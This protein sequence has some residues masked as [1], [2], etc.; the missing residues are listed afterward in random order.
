[1]IPA[2]R[3]HRDSDRDSTP[4]TQDSASR[5]EPGALPERFRRRLR[6]IAWQAVSEADTRDGFVMAAFDEQQ[7]RAELAARI[8]LIDQSLHAI[9]DEVRCLPV[10]AYPGGRELAVARDRAVAALTKWRDRYLPRLTGYQPPRV[11]GEQVEIRRPSHRP[12]KPWEIATLGIMGALIAE[13]W[14]TRA[15]A[16]ACADELVK[17]WR[18]DPR[19]AILHDYSTTLDERL[20]QLWHQRQRHRPG[21]EPST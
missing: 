20:R 5:P 4:P 14:S 13:G 9:A 12:S 21:K 15:A 3:R 8:D 16:R 11:L 17:H 1:M 2:K 10:R 7:D 18:R 6:R 19:H